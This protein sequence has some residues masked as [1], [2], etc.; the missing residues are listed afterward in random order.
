MVIYGLVGIYNLDNQNNYLILVI[1]GDKMKK[2][3]INVDRNP[4][5]LT[6]NKIQ[7]WYETMMGL[8]PLAEAQEK[9]RSGYY[10]VSTNQAIF[11]VPSDTKR[12]QY[13]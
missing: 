13:I 5:H 6:T 1:G 4:E 9:V 8:I 3:V 10:G 11:R 7:L 12:I 2:Y